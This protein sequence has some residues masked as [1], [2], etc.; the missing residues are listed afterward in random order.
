MTRALYLIL[1]VAVVPM[2]QAQTVD[3]SGTVVDAS[4]GAVASA[5]VSV[6]STHTSVRTDGDG[7][8]HIAL[9][10]GRYTLNIDAGA[11]FLQLRQTI[12]VRAG[13][14]PLTLQLKLA[15]VEET[16]DV[17][18]NDVKP[19]LD[20]SA[21]LDTTTLSGSQLEQL[22]V[23]DHDIVG[24]LT[25]F[26]DTASV[27]TSGPTI[28]VDGVEMKSAGVPK[29]AIDSVSI[30]ADPYSAE[31]SRPGRGRIEITTKPGGGDMH[32]TVALTFRNAAMSS[33]SYF[34][35]VKPPEQR[36]AVEGTFSGPLGAKRSFLF[37]FSDQSDT[38]GA[39]VHA[40]T[41]NGL[42]DA[43]V[44]ARSTRTELMGRVSEDVS[45]KQRVSLQ[46]N[47][48]HSSGIGQGVGGIVLPE[49]AV[50]SASRELD[51]F[52]TVRSLLSASRMNHFQLTLEFDREP[53]RSVSDAPSL[54][55]RDAFVA[56]GA[57]AT[58]LRTESGGKLN[59]VFTV[60]RGR[61]I[62]KAGVQ[63]PNLNRRVWDDE[64][65]RGGTYFFGSLSD[66]AA[67][68]PYAY[69][70]QQG[71]GRVSFWWREYGAFAQ[72]QIRISKTLQASVGLRY[73]W[74]DYFHDRNNFSPR[75]SLAWSPHSGSKK[76][77]R[78]GAGVFYD[79]SGV[80]P[81]AA[82]LL[83]NGT[84]LRS[85]TLLDPPYPDP[86]AGGASFANV[87]VDVTRLAP[88]VQI[89][90]TLQYSA[91][92]ETPITNALSAS[93]GYRGARGHHLFRSVDVNALLP[94]LYA[95][96]PDP[97]FGRIQE[98]RSDGH[99]RSD[100]LE[101][102][103]RGN[104]GKHFTGQVQY[105]LSRALN[106]TSG[107]FWYAS[108]PY[109]PVSSEWG[110]ADFDQRHR[111]NLLGTFTAGRW[112]NVGIAAKLYSGTPYS[113][114]AGAD[115][116]HT[117]LANARPDGIGRNTLRTPAYEDVDVRWSHDVALRGSTKE[118]AKAFTLSIEA[119]NAFN[120]ANFAG[121]IG[122]VRSPLFLR[123]TTAAPGRRLQ[124]SIEAKL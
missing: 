74:Q 14:Q 44:A 55:V 116:F 87:P 7:R 32:G 110:P 96:V 113:Q 16:V 23:L 9:P 117:G 3:V 76:V 118:H 48:K 111:L 1:F 37:T 27:A 72:D 120:H 92:Y 5:L 50:N 122:N 88:D 109:A 83:H 106:D 45:E 8:F 85:Y 15:P 65:N 77:L 19:A 60:I 78:A 11:A 69:S 13:M 49:A 70:V 119:F 26:L 80:G 102:T 94:P 95:S 28:L 86:L 21:N 47:W 24:A 68:R 64:T 6:V 115:L 40:L 79:R 89:P 31:S 101:L 18:A 38:A 121:Y 52:F 36:R 123:P 63:I 99:M 66:Y 17:T 57:Q 108:N 71:T 62:F 112:V 12:A 98:L 82:I 61:H 124:L 33:R 34:A 75:A 35:P 42:Y 59:D 91:S 114:I 30:N 39:V 67:Q 22:P 25:P 93:I 90:S 2:V 58:I 97:R 107:I 41:Q 73:D 43:N 84:T 20:T 10:A 81:V 103:M 100:A 104:A 46:F 51:A 29:A 4:G 105:T 53:N 56:G 54:V